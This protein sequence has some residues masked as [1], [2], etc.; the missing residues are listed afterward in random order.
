MSLPRI[1]S[2]LLLVALAIAPLR[3]AAGAAMA[4]PQHDMAMSAG[5]CADNTAPSDSTDNRETV[6]CCMMACAALP[7]AS[8][9]V[10]EMLAYATPPATAGPQ[11]ARSGLPPEAAT[12][13]PR[14][15]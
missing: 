2:L 9:F 6:S 13:P 12:P 7:A 3:I 14:S 8:I 4:M 1:L 15:A 11:P 5:H 10:H